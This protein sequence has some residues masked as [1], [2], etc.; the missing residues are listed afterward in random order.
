MN[1][2][3]LLSGIP[4]QYG[5]MNLGMGGMGMGQ[6]GMFGYGDGSGAGLGNGQMN[7]Y[8]RGLLGGE[9]ADGEDMDDVQKVFATFSLLN[10]AQSG[11]W[12]PQNLMQAYKLFK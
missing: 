12:S 4:M 10:P 2:N 3:M 9:G 6:G 1:K 11:S 8:R 5:R 7:R